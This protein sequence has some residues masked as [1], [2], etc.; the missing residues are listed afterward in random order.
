[1]RETESPEFLRELAELSKPEK[2]EV[3]Q[4]LEAMTEPS[5]EVE[6]ALKAIQSDFDESGKKAEVKKASNA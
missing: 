1:M 3:E 5:K 6:S 2:T 4:A